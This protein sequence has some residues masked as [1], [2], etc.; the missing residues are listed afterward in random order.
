MCIGHFYSI[1]GS[2]DLLALSWKCPPGVDPPTEEHLVEICQALVHWGLVMGCKT[3]GGQQF[4]VPDV[5]S[6]T[7]VC[8]LLCL[9][10]AR[11]FPFCCRVD[12]FFVI[13]DGSTRRP[14]TA[15]QALDLLERTNA[16][17][18]LQD[19]GYD[20]LEF[21]AAVPVPTPP[22]ECVPMLTAWSCDD[23]P[24]HTLEVRSTNVAAIVCGVL[25]AVVLV[26]LVGIAVAGVLA[27]RRRWRYIYTNNTFSVHLYRI[28]LCL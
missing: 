16:L 18:R 27:T 10:C 24:S 22:G 4:S 25:A 1:N 15:S 3:P 28:I 2:D 6:S 5:P 7:W 13:L 26:V 23:W 12:I 9:K 20:T 17:Q 8:L 21:R 14:L 19:E 11:H